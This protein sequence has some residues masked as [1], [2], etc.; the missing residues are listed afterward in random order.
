VYSWPIAK[1]QAVARTIAAVSVSGDWRKLQGK[2]KRIPAEI[3]SLPNE[4]LQIFVRQLFHEGGI[5]SWDSVNRSATICYAAAHRELLTDVQQLLLRMRVQSEICTRNA[6]ILKNQWELRVT[7]PE[8]Q[9]QFLLQIG[10]ANS[11][12]QQA[13]QWVQEL[14]DQQVYAHIVSDQVHIQVAE[15]LQSPNPTRSLTTPSLV[16]ATR[17]PLARVAEVLDEA[18]IDVLATNE[19]S[20]DPIVAIT[21]LGVQP[22]YDATVPVTHNF[23][24]EGISVHNS[25][26]QDADMVLLLHR[27]DAFDKDNER[28]GEADLILGKHRNGPTATIALGHQLHYSQFTNLSRGL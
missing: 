12:A 3:F 19:V 4:Q 21:D 10:V 11:L 26:E 25:L 24:A 2:A 23:V 17:S 5:I 27:P 18:E 9:I 14:I 1:V 8:E 6:S 28:A 7:N 16:S 22:V 20:W 13:Q 15:L